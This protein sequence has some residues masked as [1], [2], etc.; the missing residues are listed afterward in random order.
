MIG[1]IQP[2]KKK[3]HWDVAL[4]IADKAAWRERNFYQEAFRL[5]ILY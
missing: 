3:S 2:S 1:I 5:S 4:K